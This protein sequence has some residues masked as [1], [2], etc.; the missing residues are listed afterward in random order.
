MRISDWSSDVCSSDLDIIY[1]QRGKYNLTIRRTLE[2]IWNN[3]ETDKSGEEWE[4]FKVYSGR[5]WFSNG[6]HHHYS[7]DKFV[8]DCSFD[9]FA[10]LVKACASDSL[11]LAENETVEAFRSE[12]RRVGKECVS[13]WRSRWSPDH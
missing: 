3:P 6:M 12:E 5:F 11:P 4:R 9:Y 2:A 8:P 1:D 10:G 7:N 13:S